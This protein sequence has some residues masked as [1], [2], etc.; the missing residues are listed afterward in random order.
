[1][2]DANLFTTLLRSLQTRSAPVP[3][4]VAARVDGKRA[5]DLYPVRIES[6]RWTGRTLA[7]IPLDE[8]QPG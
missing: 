6:G 4:A 2:I 5:W 1:M 8:R 7:G 3:V